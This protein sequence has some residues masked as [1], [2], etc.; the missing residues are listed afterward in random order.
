VLAIDADI[1]GRGLTRLLSTDDTAASADIVGFFDALGN[2][3]DDGGAT[4]VEGAAG[5]V[6]VLPPGTP[7]TD[8]MGVVGVENVLATLAPLTR[9]FELVV[10]D[11][12]P[13][14][15]V[16]YASALLRAAASVVVV[17]P[18]RG[19][20]NE[21]ASLKERLDLIGVRPIGYVYNFGTRRP[22]AWRRVFP[23]AA[24]ADAP[25]VGR[26]ARTLAA[27][28]VTRLL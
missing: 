5:T 4:A 9:A 6:S 7:P 22:P 24:D 10:V 1:R 21:L 23:P 14:L 13:L 11:V 25:R 17:V 12:P 15:D 2:D 3:G 8:V 18:H 26:R 27:A 20:A 28:S 19:G 16:A